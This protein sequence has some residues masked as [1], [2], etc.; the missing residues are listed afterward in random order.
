[1]TT[2]DDAATLNYII[3]HRRSVSQQQYTGELVDDA[4][5]NQMLENARWAPNH[6]LTEPWHF[7]VFTGEGLKRLGKEQA[8][9]YKKV[10]EADGTYSEDRYKGLLTK[11]TLSSHIIAI[12]VKRDARKAL[13]VIEEIGAVYCAVENMYLTATAYGVGCYL[14][15]GGITYFEEAKTLFGLGQD[16]ALLGFLHIGI[17]K[18]NLPD[19][20]RKPLD[21]KAQWVRE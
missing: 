6:K 3:R 4:V 14:S 16:D 9:L 10:T 1:M 5:V 20:R 13:P 2:S 7:I 12:G 15:S 21:E 19:S 11:V 18:D 17:P 8:A